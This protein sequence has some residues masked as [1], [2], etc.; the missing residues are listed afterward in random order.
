MGRRDPVEKSPWR[1]SGEEGSDTWM[2]KSTLQ[3]VLV[4]LGGGGDGLG[5]AVPCE[6]AVKPLLINTACSDLGETERFWP[7]W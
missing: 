7:E 3:C 2:W 5:E 1:P 4:L 6:H